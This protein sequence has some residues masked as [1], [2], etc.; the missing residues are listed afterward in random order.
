VRFAEWF[1]AGVAILFPAGHVRAEEP[2]TAPSAAAAAAKDDDE[3]AVP[4]TLVDAAKN[5]FVIVKTYFRKDTSETADA[6]DD[7]WMTLRLYDEYVD[8]KRPALTTG[9]VIGAEGRVL[10]ADYGLEDRFIDRIEI[11]AGGK[12]AAAR[13]HRLLQDAP[14]ILLKPEGKADVKLTPLTFS[15]LKDEGVNT[16][17]LEADL[18]QADDQW[19][20]RFGSG[21]PAIR[22]DAGPAAGNVYFGQRASVGLRNMPLSRGLSESVAGVTIVADK[23]GRPVGC[24]TTPFLDLRQEECLWKGPELLKAEGMDWPALT[25]AENACRSRLV[26][27]VQEVVLVLRSGGGGADMDEP[28]PVPYRPSYGHGEAA[29]REISLYGLAVG[30]TQVLVPRPLDSALAR[31]IEKIYLKHSPAKRQPARFVGAFRKIGAFLVAAEGGDLP[32]FA[33]PAAGDPER[34]KPFWTARLRKRLGAKYVDLATNRIFGKDRGYEGKY[35]WYAARGINPGTLLVSF[36]GELLGAYVQERGEHEEERR[37]DESRRYRG[38]GDLPHRIFTISELRGLLAEPAKH[39]DAKVEVKTREM[40]R[41]R[42]WFGVE[43]VPVTAELAEMLKVEKPTKDGQLGFLLNAVYA[44]SPAEKMGMKVG[45]IL[46]KLQAPGMPYPIE[47]ASRLAGA[48]GGYGSYRRWGDYGGG[49]EDAESMGPIEA[50]WKNRQN[51]LTR[52]LDAV[53]VG[54]VIEITY[55][56]P[57]GEAAGKGK[58]QTLQYPIE[59]APP[60]LESAPRWQN[61]KLGLTVKDL[62]YEVRHALNLNDPAAGVIVAKVESGSPTLVAK[63]FPNEVVTQL[64]DQPLKSARQMRDLVAAA[65]QAGRDK[66]RLTLLRL[67]KTRF[68]DLAIVEYDAKDDEGLDEATE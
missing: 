43:F 47:L 13:P 5:S 66:V 61:R 44:G 53:G 6:A 29:G 39:L 45:D 23:Q 35:N 9:I 20:L 55:Y 34:M 22:F 38:G 57:E 63:V 60:D 27:C 30:P 21:R 15:P 52:A 48:S 51:F 64:N 14:A 37:L 33:K 7:N 3:P 26:Q 40:A 65:K 17:L 58:T 46:L 25:A 19:R 62:T 31:Q 4:K 59:L 68:A 56:R 67:G 1:L 10:T 12:T 24:C 36:R 16:S 11:E 2:S 50:T 42:S 32:A 49:G 54:K 18:F 8:K 41:R 28:S